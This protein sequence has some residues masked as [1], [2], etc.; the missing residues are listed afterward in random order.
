[1]RTA[2]GLDGAF[3]SL[4]T[5]AMPMHVGSLHLFQTPPRYRKDFTDEI[6]RMIAGR[7]H[8][9]PIFT[10]R[11]AATPLNLANPVWIET[12]ADLD[13][14]IQRIDLPAPGTIAQLQERVAELHSRLLDRARP[15]WMLYVFEGLKD[16]RKAYYV[17]IH[18]ALLDG[19]AG[20]AL[21][22]ALFDLSANP[23]PVAPR[24][25][26]PADPEPGA[27]GL[28]A[29]AIRHD[30]AQYIKLARNLPDIARMLGG[31]A[32][33]G[34]A[35]S[36]AKPA[37]KLADNIALGPRTPL[38]VTITGERG[39]AGLTLPLA[40]VKVIAHACDATINDVALALCSGMLRRWLTRH[41]GLPKKPLMAA[42]PISLRAK[43][44]TEMTTQATLSLVNI[45]T[46]IAD[47]LK[48]IS[49]IHAASG[50]TKSVA[51]KAKSL[52]PTDFPTIGGPWLLGAA[53]ELYGRSRI[54]SLAPPLANVV[55]SN[56]PGPPMPLYAAGLEM[57]DYWPL[58]IVTHGVGLNITLMSYNG[59]LGVGFTTARC[60]VEDAGELVADFRSALAQLQKA[61]AERDAP[62][63]PKKRAARRSRAA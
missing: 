41:G 63:A 4:E 34:A 43:G 39:F 31:M 3:L 15:L 62:A 1:M 2:S 22:A 25:K 35:E 33:G 14:H 19:Q 16:R 57:T 40:E 56:V 10:R 27:L 28:I 32:F 17:K 29:N 8:L 12:E 61:V 44:D 7:L 46:N 20:A 60:A 47:P 37:G 48:R 42:M 52:I 55:I 23:E 49:A 58:S 54:A 36:A 24:A 13:F 9:A 18:H 6:R 5:R 50:A 30:A 45:A 21:A 53:A 59:T 11:M 38:N 26:K 51:G